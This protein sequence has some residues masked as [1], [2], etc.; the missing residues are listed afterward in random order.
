MKHFKLLGVA[1]MAVFA[2]GAMLASTG[3][4]ALT[5]PA[6]LPIA[7]NKSFT[8]ANVGA[9]KLESKAG[10][11]I[12]CKTATAT[13]AQE[14]DTLGTFHITFEGCETAIVGKCTS[15]G[16]AEGSILTLGSFHYVLDTLSTSETSVA[17]LFLPGITKFECTK[18]VKNEVKGELVCPLTKPLVSSKTHEFTCAKGSTAGSQAVKK[19]Y[20]DGGTLVEAK[21]ESALNGG[22]FEESNEQATATTTFTNKAVAFEN[23]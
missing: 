18:F 23:D 21:L 4:S 3:A 19:Y 9:P 5:L 10:S 17:V 1:L 15:T 6:L 14:T 22:T 13:G 20:N 16:D 2:I 11:V 8:G 12:E 7:E